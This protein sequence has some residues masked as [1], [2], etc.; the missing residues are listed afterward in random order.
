M[1]RSVRNS[2]TLKMA[3]SLIS[4]ALVCLLGLMS[5]NLYTL[6]KASALLESLQRLHIDG[7]FETEIKHLPTA[8]KQLLLFGYRE[9]PGLT[10]ECR[11]LSPLLS[12]TII[13]LTLGDHEGRLRV[14]NLESIIPSSEG[15]RAIQIT[16][17]ARDVEFVAMAIPN[18]AHPKALRL[19]LPADMRTPLLR[20]KTSC[21]LLPGYC[22]RLQEYI[23][24]LPL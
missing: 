18:D 15:L 20:F 7:D 10:I 11:L 9:G 16:R 19:R 2:Q 1:H 6:K 12:H 17:S 21:F 13:A 14:M 3:F 23:V 4:F 5:Y 22:K 24:V 8:C